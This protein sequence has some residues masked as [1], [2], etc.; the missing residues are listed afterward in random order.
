[1]NFI[2]LWAFFHETRLFYSV[3]YAPMPHARPKFAFIRTTDQH[4]YLFFKRMGRGSTSAGLLWFKSP[5]SLVHLPMLRP[6]VL[7]TPE[8]NLRFNTTISKSNVHVYISSPPTKSLAI[9][10]FLAPSCS[11]VPYSWSWINWYRFLMGTAH[12]QAQSSVETQYN[13][14]YQVG[15]ESW[16]FNA[17]SA[18]I[19]WGAV[20]TDHVPSYQFCRKLC[21][22]TSLLSFQLFHISRAVNDTNSTVCRSERVQLRKKYSYCA[23]NGDFSLRCLSNQC[24]RIQ[25]TV[26]SI[27]HQIKR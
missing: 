24:T 15:F 10:D 4:R 16:E 18:Y 9:L 19:R 3:Q 6:Y 2:V 11:S 1:M 25:Q 5:S 27:E 7:Q 8:L 13:R 17:S 12:P 23:H 20:Q 26:C 22:R 21:V 14:L